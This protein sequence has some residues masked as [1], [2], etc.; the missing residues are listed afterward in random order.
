MVLCR[1]F[2]ATL[3]VITGI[4]I[5]YIFESSNDIQT[6]FIDLDSRPSE[7]F[8]EVAEK[9]SFGIQTLI[10]SYKKLLGN[11]FNMSENEL[12]SIVKNLGNEFDFEYREEMHGVAKYAQVDIND[13][14]FLHLHY[15]LS[16]M[17][18]TILCVDNENTVWMMRTFDY[19]LA[20][21]LKALTINMDF[22][23][24]NRSLFKGTGIAGMVFL[25]S[26]VRR[27]QFTF[28]VNR[29]VTRGEILEG[30]LR[31]A[32]AQVEATGNVWPAGLIFRR[33]LSKEH[34]N[35]REAVLELSKISLLVPVHFII[36]G[37]RNNQG[38][39]FSR[40][41]GKVVF[42]N[43]LDINNGTWFILITNRDVGSMS[44]HAKEWRY[45]AARSAMTK[46]IRSNIND[47]K[48]WNILKTA[49]LKRSVF[50]SLMSVESYYLSSVLV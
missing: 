49:R 8:K 9:Y 31:I 4:F 10:Q 12:H 30:N 46:L 18:T 19:F 36:G 32:A 42:S 6:F 26:G 20:N 35:F 16:S 34:F 17:C 29:R 14:Y 22:Q 39:I 28:A 23:K 50:Y 47:D 7:R 5:Q 45:Q 11:R 13:V 33:L 48:A 27:N 15:E 44:W 24:R 25:M 37:R 38:I 21:Q 41:R 1:L 43:R 40:S 2:V 3:F